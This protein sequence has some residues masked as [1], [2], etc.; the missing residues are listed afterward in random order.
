MHFVFYDEKIH[1]SVEF[2]ALNKT[3]AMTNLNISDWPLTS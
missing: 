1:E 3:P 2:S